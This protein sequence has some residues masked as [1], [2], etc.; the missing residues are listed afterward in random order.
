MATI[1]DKN[2]IDL[3]ITNN[4]YYEDDPRAYMIVEYTNSYGNITYGVT[5]VNESRER[6]TRYLNETQYVQNPKVI[7]HS[8][9]KD[10]K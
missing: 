2:L 10:I 9:N 7:W 5:W 8:E 6:R 4:G 3:I 1:D